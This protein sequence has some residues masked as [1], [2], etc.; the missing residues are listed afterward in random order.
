MS[1]PNIDSE[2][3]T[4]R[5]WAIWLKTNIRRYNEGKLSDYEKNLFVSVSREF[6]VELRRP[7]EIFIEECR[8]FRRYMNSR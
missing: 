4:E 3:E 7:R 8:S 1:L 6:N 2:N 5:N